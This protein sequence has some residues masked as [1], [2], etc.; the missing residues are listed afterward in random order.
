MQLQ[1][2]DG[3]RL[4]SRERLFRI[5][6][7]SPPRSIDV[8]FLAAK[9]SDQIFASVAAVRAAANNGDHAIQVIKCGP[10]AFQN[11]LAVAGFV[12][13]I[14]SP[15]PHHVDPM[16]DEVL[17][18]LDQPHFLRLPVDHGQQDHAEAFLHRRMLE[19][20]IEYDLGLGSALQFDHDA[21]AIAIALV[22]NIG[23]IVDRLLIHQISDALNQARLIHLIRN[24]CNNDRLLVLG[25]AL[26]RGASPHHETSAARSISLKDS[27]AAM[28][29]SRRGKVRPLHKFQNFRQLRRGIVYQRDRRVDNLSQIM[30]RNFRSHPHRNSV[31]A[32]HQQVGIACRQHGRLCLGPVVVWIKINRLFVE[33]LKQRRRNARQPSFCISIRRRRIAID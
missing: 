8:D 23:D 20:L 17:D 3:I 32:I 9:I 16:I 21:H 29:N 30:G 31:R 28:N 7:R 6:L 2:K 15:P 19:E 12:Q 22:A 24:L 10:V 13:Q 14:R 18:R 11:V 27:S 4:L 33:I 1:F 5:Q 25:N 26:N